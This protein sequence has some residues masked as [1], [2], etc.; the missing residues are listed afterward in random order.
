MMPQNFNVR[1][2]ATADLPTIVR[3]L[4]EDT[5]GSQRE[6]SSGATVPQAY[7]DAFADIQREPNSTVFV[8]EQE[9]DIIATFHLMFLPSLSFQGGK[10]AQIESVRVAERLRGQGLGRKLMHWAI[11][12][13]R[14]AGCVMV[15]L[16]TNK[17][18][19]D[20][21]RFYK[22]LGFSATHEGM[23]LML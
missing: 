1:P 11:D 15:Q 6:S 19:Q 10:R 23:K 18:R 17:A 13:A 2:A 16:T 8:A 4:L 12:Q 7:Y 21:H 9:G 20:A 22:R 3:L 5:L 14:D